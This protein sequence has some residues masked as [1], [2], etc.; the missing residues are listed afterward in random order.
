MSLRLK[1][2]SLTGFIVL[3]TAIYV[4]S[5]WLP[6]SL[7]ISE[8]NLVDAT[9]KELSIVAEGL[10]TPLLQNQL[11]TIHESLDA[12]RTEFPEW[13]SLELYDQKGDLVYPLMK[14]EQREGKYYRSLSR[15]IKIRNSNLATIA[16]TVDLGPQLQIFQK[17]TNELFG[18]LAVGLILGLAGI[19]VFIDFYIRKPVHELAHAAEELAKENYSVNLPKVKNDEIG[20][21]INK[22]SIMR[23]GIQYS[24]EKLLQSEQQ[25]RDFGASASDWY[26]EMD[27]N[28]RFSYFSDSFTGVTGV[29]QDYLLG[30]TRQESGNPGIEP[31]RW[32]NH[33]DILADHQPFR[34]FIHPRTQADG[35]VVWLSINGKPVFD[36]DGSFRGYRG[37]GLD[38]TEV[39]NTENELVQAKTEAEDA[40]KAKSEFLSSMS[41][42]LRTPMNAILGFTQM[43]ELNS[44]EPLSETQQSCVKHIMTGG[45]HL[46]GLID[47]VLDLA[48]IETGKLNISF[49]EVRLDEVYQECKTLIDRS[50]ADRGIRI[51]SD[52]GVANSINADYTRFKQVLLNFL[53]NSVKYNSDGGLIRLACESAPEGMLRISVSDTGPGIPK[54]D[55]AGLFEP[56]NRLGREASEIEGTGIGLTITK[57]LVEAMNGRIGFESDVGKGS[58]FWVEFPEMENTLASYEDG[59]VA[60]KQDEPLDHQPLEAKVLYVEDNPANRQLMEVVIDKIS[61]VTLIC[62]PDAELGISMAEDQKPDLILMDINLPGMDG[63]AAK[64][65]LDGMDATKNIPVI[66][67]S[68]AAMENDVKRGAEAGFKTYLT[69]PF[70]V[71]NLVEVIK[72]ELVASSSASGM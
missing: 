72:K 23:S 50:A 65:V 33:L 51:E 12:L 18:L 17:Q 71:Q 2:I 3:L 7:Q 35:S 45:V 68:A 36:P 59:G 9:Q 32:Q 8:D 27:E 46:L 1:I 42:E 67:I 40:N 62:A 69:K 29:S 43:L 22:F 38:V 53:S 15:A 66:A 41:H 24:A 37:T 58:T 57:Q 55:Q 47:Q 20:R 52:L 14:T 39:K 31:E 28:L 44:E 48:K 60:L 11:A 64:K 30:K 61:G 19:I 56:F 16:V 6:K 5:F 63:I 49:E 70:D 34:N 26:W 10:I 4:V 54:E 25:L 13:V 21:L